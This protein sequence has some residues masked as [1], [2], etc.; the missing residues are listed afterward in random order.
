MK[1]LVNCNF[2]CSFFTN[3]NAVC[4]ETQ[5]LQ[6]SKHYIT[7]GG[8]TMDSTQIITA[9]IFS[10]LGLMTLIILSKPIKFL[11]KTIFNAG[12]GCA[13]ITVLHTIGFPI[14]INYMTILFTGILGIPGIVGLLLLCV[15]L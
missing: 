5:L 13:I 15:L 10:C 8:M 14:G 2:K 6:I 3:S 4:K 12:I 1:K 11:L 9:M 7:K